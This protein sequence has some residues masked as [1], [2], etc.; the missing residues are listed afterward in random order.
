MEARIGV[1]DSGKVIE[2]EVDDTDK[3]RSEL[4]RAFASEQEVYWFTDVKQHLVGIPVARIA[5]V[6]IESEESRR[7]VGFAPGT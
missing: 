3:F 2:I 7:K 4:E 5:Y 6:E 1:A